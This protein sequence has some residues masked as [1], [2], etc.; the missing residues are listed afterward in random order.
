MKLLRDI[1]K[2]NNFLEAADH[3]LNMPKDYDLWAV[4]GTAR[5]LL[6]QETLPFPKDLDLLIN[7]STE[8]KDVATAQSTRDP[9]GS[10]GDGQKYSQ[11]GV[12]FDVFHN[13]LFKWLA[14]A[15]CYGDMVAVRVTDGFALARPEVFV[16]KPWDKNP[17]WNGPPDYLI[18]HQSSLRR[19]ADFIEF[20]KQSTTLFA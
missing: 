5:Y 9:S 6:S 17:A 10:S 14:G 1:L 8:G 7:I 12:L 11:G 4:G 3:V 15:P 2:R 16:Y 13:N 20:Y 18:R 19:D